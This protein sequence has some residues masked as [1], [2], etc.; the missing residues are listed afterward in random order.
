[1]LHLNVQSQSPHSPSHE[2]GPCS[3]PAEAPRVQRKRPSTDKYKE[4]AHRESTIV[5]LVESL[6][7]GDLEVSL[8]DLLEDDVEGL[9]SSREGRGEADVELGVAVLLESLSTLKS[10]LLAELCKIG[11]ERDKGRT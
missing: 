8:A 7:L 10:L 4:G 1:M 11:K 2:P 9:V 3:C 5:A 6:V